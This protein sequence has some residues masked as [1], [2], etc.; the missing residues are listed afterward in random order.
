MT[1]RRWVE[2]KNDVLLACVVVPIDEEPRHALTSA[3]CPCNVR[4][5]K[6]NNGWTEYV[7]MA[8]DHREVDEY[9]KRH[10]SH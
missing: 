7:H 5:R 2:Y 1:D 6:L 9:L 3:Y 10:A 8:F 4:V